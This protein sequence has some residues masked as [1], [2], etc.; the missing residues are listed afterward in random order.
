MRSRPVLPVLLLAVSLVAA[1][2]GGSGTKAAPSPTPSATATPTPS[3][4]PVVAA[5]ADWLTGAPTRQTGPVVAVKVDNSVLARPYQRGLRSA[6]VVYQE[7]VEGGST[8]LLAVLESS[9]AGT[10]EV[11]PIR[12]VRES[13]IDLLREY[14]GIAV[15]FSGG[16]TGV[17]ATFAKAARQ[18]QVVD[19]SYDAIPPAYRL[20]ERRKDARNFFT[21]AAKLVSR[22]PGAGPRDIGLR[23]GATPDPLAVPAPLATAVFSIQSSLRIRFSGGSYVLS[24]G[25]SVLPVSPANVV[26]QY[27]KIRSSRY[28]DV[29]GMPTPF[30]VT[31]GGGKA[32]VLRDGTA[33]T[34]TWKRDG[35]G[36]TRFLGAGGRDLPLKPGPTW[37]VLL[38]STGSLA[39]R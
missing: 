25:G 8:R 36:V 21:T 1:C 2:S 17:K 3:A 28:S 34:G 39:L 29:H 9:T 5:A 37:V 24:Q 15:G 26:V 32:V 12:S 27:V 23:F 22:K 20:G 11:G 10:T 4:T 30:T 19:A 31:T 35:Y 16:N 14:G 7:L 38:P 6:A 18:G 13:D 33:V